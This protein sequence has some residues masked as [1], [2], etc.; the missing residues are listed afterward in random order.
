MNVLIAE[1]DALMR[2]MLQQPRL[3][4]LWRRAQSGLAR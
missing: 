2:L 1:D 4:W 3:Q